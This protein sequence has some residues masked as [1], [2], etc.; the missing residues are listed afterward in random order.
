MR[1]F[2]AVALIVAL[3][4]PAFAKSDHVQRAGEGQM[5]KIQEKAAEAAR[6]AYEKSLSN[7]PD[8]GSTDPWGAVRPDDKPKTAAAR[9]PDGSPAVRPRQ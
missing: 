5:E 6:D 9:R 1:A 7:I 2:A 8:Q 3:A 4:A